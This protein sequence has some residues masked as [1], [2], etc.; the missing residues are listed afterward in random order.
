MIKIKYQSPYFAFGV[1]AIRLAPVVSDLTKSI[2][3]FEITGILQNLKS[4]LSN[5][6][7]IILLK[8]KTQSHLIL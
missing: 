1:L 8:S 5:K 7:Q 3:Y 6:I 2:N 4:I